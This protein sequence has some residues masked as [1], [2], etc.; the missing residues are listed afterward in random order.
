MV[1]EIS[2]LSGLSL[3]Y[4]FTIQKEKL[5]LQKICARWIPHLLTPEQKKGRV[6]KASV[7]L[8]SSR[9]RTLPLEGSCDW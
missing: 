7:L 5:K 9:T 4:V 6:E 8:S 2:D 1:E 3:S